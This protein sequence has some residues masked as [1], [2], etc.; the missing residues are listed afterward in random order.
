[1]K[2][3]IIIAR[4]LAAACLLQASL[5][6]AQTPNGYSSIVHL[7]VVV[8]SGAFASTL[9]VHNPNASPVNVQFN[10]T[11]AGATPTAGPVDCGLHA[12]PAGSTS[13]FDFAALCPLSGASNFGSMRIYETSPINRPISVY[14]RV[15]SPVAG[16][17]FSVEG[18]P[19]GNFANDKGVSVAVG[20]KRSSLLPGYQTNCFVGSIGEPVTVDV[21]LYAADNTQLGTT[22]TV[23]VPAGGL[24]RMLDVFAVAG[25]PAG[26][27]GNVRAEFRQNADQVGNPSYS[28]FCTVQNNTTFDADFRIAKAVSPDDLTLQYT[29]TVNK[30]A[31][32][33]NIDI[34]PG[35]KVVFAMLVKHPDFLACR[36]IGDGLP[37]AELRIVDPSGNVVAG[38]ND[39]NDTTEFF[40]G[41]K[42]TVANG[43]NAR[44]LV[45]VG[46]RDGGGIPAANFNLQC[47][48]GNGASKPLVVA[49]LP[50]D[51]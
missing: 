4:L 46:A 33:N 34:P 16:N 29:S 32:G 25:A 6:A 51:F 22:Q 15:Q 45:E 3:S 42:S 40:T 2:H 12:I 9:Y 43:Q 30:D 13:E 47:R 36:V 11:G 31:L 21:A 18:F 10:Y 20:L 7:P 1:M 38:G 8:N 48:S 14:T 37:N 19:I 39:V 50:D 23:S 49:I 41:E 5:V 17:G 24:A 26:D 28:A 27:L 44:W 35:A